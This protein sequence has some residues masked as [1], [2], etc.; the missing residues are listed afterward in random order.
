MEGVA[1]PVN[2]NASQ[3]LVFTT[4]DEILETVTMTYENNI[5]DAP[6]S[7]PDGVRRITKQDNGL[8][9]ITYTFRGR[10]KDP[11]ADIQKLIDFAKLQQVESTSTTNALEFGK[12][13]FFTDNTTLVPFNL[14][15]EVNDAG[16]IRRGLTIRSFTINRNSEVPKNFDFEIVMTFGGVF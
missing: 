6:V 3:K 2:L 4:P 1:L 12:F 15:P 10:F 5:K 7:N 9:G 11:S 14:D 8:L 13:G 16:T